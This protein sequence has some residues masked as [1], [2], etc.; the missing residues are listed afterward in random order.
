[1][2]GPERPDIKGQLFKRSLAS[3]KQDRVLSH[4]Q[5]AERFY[6]ST[7]YREEFHEII[8]RRLEKHLSS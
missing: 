3:V 8:W 7:I 2:S 1:M 5:F 4:F 6:I